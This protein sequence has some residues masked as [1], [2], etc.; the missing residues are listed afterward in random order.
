[1][2]TT[3][4]QE[5]YIEVTDLGV[6]LRTLL[7]VAADGY[8][9]RQRRKW[10]VRYK[11]AVIGWLQIKD[12]HLKL[13]KG[14]RNDVNRSNPAPASR[15]AGTLPGL[16]LEERG[17]SVCTQGLPCPADSERRLDTPGCVRDVHTNDS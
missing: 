15:Q 7:A 2:A 9:V 10:S 3:L 12:D 17:T 16:G 13:V 5:G 8:K 11:G 14:K 6:T 1:M 4:H